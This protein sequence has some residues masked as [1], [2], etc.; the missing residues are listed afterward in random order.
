MAA[1]RTRTKRARSAGGVSRDRGRVVLLTI[2]SRILRGNRPGDPHVR[3]LPVYL[4]PGYDD[5]SERYPVLLALTGFM[6]TGRMLLNVSAWGETLPQRL[7]RLHR[8]GDI[9]SMIVAMPDCFTRYGGSQY[10]DSSA[11]GR[12]AAHLVDEIVPLLDARLRTL[13]AARHRGIFGKSSGGYG[14]LVHAMSNPEVFGAVACHSGDMGFEY[15]YLPD[16]PKFLQQMEKY[17]GVQGFLRAFDRAPRKTGDQMTALNILAM[18]A[19]YS[20]N[21]RRPLGIDLPVDLQ[22]G[23]IVARVWER[24]LAHDPVRLASGFATNMRRLRLLFVDCGRQ[25]EYNLLWG[26]RQFVSKLVRARVRHVYEEFD[27]GHRDIS[28]RY[29]RS[30]PLLWA[31]VQPGSSR[32]R[33]PSGAVARR[34]A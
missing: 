32:R 12:Y 31:A 30:L 8:D 13:A 24:W 16:F 19:C 18:A 20:P 11:T 27:D 33:T 1:Q 28:Y 22:T 5:S 26:A 9:G 25:D 17:G 7:D 23:A 15:S 6:G 29:E 10:L 2:E 3:D 21:T 34:K 14:A 4:P